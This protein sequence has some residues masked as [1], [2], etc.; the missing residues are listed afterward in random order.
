M[1]KCRESRIRVIQPKDIGDYKRRIIIIAEE[2]RR[3]VNLLFDALDTD[4]QEKEKFV[5]L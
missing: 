4:V 5:V 2:K 3:A 1:N